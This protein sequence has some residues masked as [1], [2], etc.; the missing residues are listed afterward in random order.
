[1]DDDRLAALAGAAGLR[2]ASR[3]ADDGRLMLLR[4]VPQPARPST[5]GRPAP[6]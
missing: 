2:V 5:P 3:L 1:V 6:A 4:P